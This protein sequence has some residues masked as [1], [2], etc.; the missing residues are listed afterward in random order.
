MDGA[1]TEHAVEAALAAERK[2]VLALG[3]YA[4]EIPGAILVTHEKIPS[5]RF[6][7]VAVTGIAVDRQAAF[8]ER[9]LDHYF[10]RALRPRFRIPRPVPEHLDR[11]LRRFAFRPAETP[12]ELLLDDGR[13]VPAADPVAEVRPAAAEEVDLIASF[14]TEVPERPELR[15]ALDV[16][17]HHPP[18]GEELVPLIARIDDVP[19]S[20]ALVYRAG[21]S[22]GIHLVTTRPEARGRG[23]ASALVAYARSH[24]PAD[25]AVRHAILSEAPRGSA[26]LATLGFSPVASFTEY[27]LP[28]DAELAFP[29]PG[30]PTPPRWRPPR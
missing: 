19:S 20:A 29:P 17:W 23:A 6:N 5:P 16:A 1:S 7:C 11:G 15:A 4:L 12:L 30:P 28:R 10:Q 9:A 18:P 26:H 3:G 25:G 13:P 2:F 14:W 21:R 24:G 27:V 22:A 8:F